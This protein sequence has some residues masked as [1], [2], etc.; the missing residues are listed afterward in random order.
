MTRTTGKSDEL[1]KLNARLRRAQADLRKA[2]VDAEWFERHHATHTDAHA[3]YRKR[4]DEVKA[5][6]RAATDAIKARMEYEHQHPEV[7]AK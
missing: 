6:I 3:L 4:I 5:E 2:T 1:K 7:K